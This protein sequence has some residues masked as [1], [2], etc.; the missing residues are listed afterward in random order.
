MSVT[1]KNS[2]AMEEPRWLAPM[3]TFSRCSRGIIVASE[4]HRI[5]LRIRGLEMTGF[6]A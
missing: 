4:Q 5:Y 2:I 6:P 1:R 3:E